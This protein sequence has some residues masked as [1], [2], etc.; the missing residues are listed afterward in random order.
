MRAV[1]RA[2]VAGK[3]HDHAALLA[4]PSLIRHAAA[5][6]EGD[7]LFCLSHRYYLAKGLSPQERL[8]AARHHYEQEDRLYRSAYS[9]QVYQAG[10][11]VLWSADSPLHH[12]DIV[13]QPGRDVAYEGG[14][15][16][17]LRMDGGCLCVL[18]FSQ[19]PT[20]IFHAG[21][22][23]PDTIHLVSRRHL[24]KERDH[25]ADYNKTFHR[26][27][28]A[29]MVFAALEGL[30]LAQG[31]SH[32][33]GIAPERHPS[34]RKDLNPRFRESYTEFWTSLGGKSLG[35]AGYL[36]ELPMRLSSLHDLDASKRKRALQR[37]AHLDAVRQTA[38]ARIAAM[39]LP[40]RA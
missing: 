40:Q 2:H 12:Y 4:S 19:I 36:V 34:D 15:S 35:P 20:R 7:P 17:A 32:V 1:R 6:G 27:T 28:P 24:T 25:Q 39:L 30:V 26:S 21:T 38:R 10:G 18:S 14:L 31:R 3:N 22:D 11:L 37:R 23:L 5:E 33:L 9:E 13:L 8:V 16:L 29:H